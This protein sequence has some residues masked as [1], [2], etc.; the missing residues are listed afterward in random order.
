MFSSEELGTVYYHDA[1]E[2]HAYVIR[3]L[4]KNSQFIK[5]AQASS[6][7]SMIND[8]MSMARSQEDAWL[9]SIRRKRRLQAE[10]AAAQV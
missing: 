1:L 6:F 8:L 2:A 4:M 5:H 10:A 7:D 9:E 3:M